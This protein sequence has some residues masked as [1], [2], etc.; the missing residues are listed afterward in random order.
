M[1]STQLD[2]APFAVTA[3]H[4]YPVRNRISWCEVE[5]RPHEYGAG[6]PKW[7]EVEDVIRSVALLLF[8][9][10][11]QLSLLLVRLPIRR[12]RIILGGLLI[13]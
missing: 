3:H 8:E 10:L 11:R 7:C 4:V 1:L 5:N 6:H 13:A 2:F 12:V 9:Q